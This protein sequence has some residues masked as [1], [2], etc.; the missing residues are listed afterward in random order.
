MQHF[1]ATCLRSYLLPEYQYQKVHP[2]RNPKHPQIFLAE[3][4]RLHMNAYSV[5]AFLNQPGFPHSP[6]STSQVSHSTER[7]RMEESMGRKGQADQSI[8]VTRNNKL[9]SGDAVLVMHSSLSLPPPPPLAT[10]HRDFTPHHYQSSETIHSQSS[11]SDRQ[12]HTDMTSH[13]CRG[14][15]QQGPELPTATLTRHTKNQKQI[16][17]TPVKV[18]D[19]IVPETTVMHCS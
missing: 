8:T 17:C 11:Q 14:T 13:L 15:R 19:K 6:S 16:K 3:M 9:H 1:A 2:S 7:L 5:T 4:H 18:L 12:Q 10:P